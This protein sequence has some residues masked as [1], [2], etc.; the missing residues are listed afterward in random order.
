MPS[1]QEIGDSPDSGAGDATWA[2]AGERRNQ[3]AGGAAPGKSFSASA[4]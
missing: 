4:R 1:Y 3:A 2:L